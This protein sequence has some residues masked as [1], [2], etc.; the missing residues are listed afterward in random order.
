VYGHF[1]QINILTYFEHLKSQ[2]YQL[3]EWQVS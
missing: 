3:I 2:I 1:E